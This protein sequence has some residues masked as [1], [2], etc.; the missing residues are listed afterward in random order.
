MY[1]VWAH[2]NKKITNT[3]NTENKNFKIDVARDEKSTE[4]RDHSGC[5]IWSSLLISFHPVGSLIEELVA[6][7]YVANLLVECRNE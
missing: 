4:T 1:L 6:V 7:Q 3:E 5:K 2:T